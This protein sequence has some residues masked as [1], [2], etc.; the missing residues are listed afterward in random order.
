MTEARASSVYVQ[1]ID[2]LSAAMGFSAEQTRA[3]EANG[4]LMLGGTT[5]GVRHQEAEG[6]MVMMAGI[7]IPRCDR[8]ED[9]CASLLRAQ[10]SDAGPAFRLFAQ[11]PA[12]GWLL[13]QGWSLPPR[14]VLE[15]HEMLACLH[16]LAAQA[17]Q[18]RHTFSLSG[19][20]Q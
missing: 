18:W 6:L 11:D 8:E 20:L 3:F 12:S 14:D 7:G 17:V 9:V 16:T 2:R 13:V 1:A 19:A 10:W 4:L 5:V 15:A